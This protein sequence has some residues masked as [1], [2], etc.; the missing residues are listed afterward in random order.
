MKEMLQQITDTKT[1]EILLDEHTDT[2]SIVGYTD[3]VVQN[4]IN[5]GI[6]GYLHVGYNVGGNIA[7]A[8]WMP[9]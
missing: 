2:D 3:G 9:E 8:E 5:I 4:C 7:Q 6:V 1:T